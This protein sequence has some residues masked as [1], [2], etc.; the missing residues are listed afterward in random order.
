[1]KSSC[2]DLDPSMHSC[3]AYGSGEVISHFCVSFPFFINWYYS[4][5][6]LKQAQQ[7]MH[8][9]RDSTILILHSIERRIALDF[10]FKFYIIWVTLSQCVGM[11]FCYLRTQG[12]YINWYHISVYQSA[13]F[14][15]FKTLFLKTY[16]NIWL[17][18]TKEKPYYLL[19]LF[20]P[21]TQSLIIKTS[22]IC[23]LP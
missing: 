21:L 6:A 18:Q 4:M 1:M 9:H 17:P 15:L 7:A 16:N 3:E 14:V 11:H 13:I 12:T 2:V 23:T 19:R 10:F 8:K 22:A 5:N 20:S